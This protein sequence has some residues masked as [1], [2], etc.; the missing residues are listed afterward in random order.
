MSFQLQCN[1]T[2]IQ[3]KHYNPYCKTTLSYA[4]NYPIPNNHKLYRR[5][6]FNVHFTISKHELTVL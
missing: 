4:Q 5:L 6:V 1:N 3:A 2:Y